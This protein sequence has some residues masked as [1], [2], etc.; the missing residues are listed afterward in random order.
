MINLRAAGAPA[1]FSARVDGFWTSIGVRQFTLDA[2]DARAL[3]KYRKAATPVPGAA[4]SLRHIIRLD[5]RA[6][7][8]IYPDRLGG[9]AALRLVDEPDL[10]SLR[11]AVIRF[12]QLDR[13]DRAFGALYRADTA[14][15]DVMR[16]TF[17]LE[18]H[19]AGILPHL[20]NRQRPAAG[21]Y[22]PVAALTER[23]VLF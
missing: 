6:A 7:D 20:I 23:A 11:G 12:G 15:L 19:A 22:Q 13:F 3:E 21:E 14:A 1:A 5:A 8:Q 16:D 10:R 4:C 18:P 17:A 9:R 2:L